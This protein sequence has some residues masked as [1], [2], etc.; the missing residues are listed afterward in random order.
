VNDL[1]SEYS[2]T[3]CLAIY[4]LVSYPG[5]DTIRLIRPMLQDATTG[6]R[7]FF[8][9]DPWNGGKEKRVKYYPVR[10]AANLALALLGEKLDWP[11]PF[12]RDDDELPDSFARGF[13]DRTYFP[14]GSWT[15]FEDLLEPPPKT[16]FDFL[17]G[18]TPV[19]QLHDWRRLNYTFAFQ[20]D[21][22]E[23]HKSVEAE[24]LPKGFKVA[25]VDPD[26]FGRKWRSVTYSRGG[27]RVSL[28]EHTRYMPQ[29]EDPRYTWAEDLQGW[30]S[31]D[32]I[33]GRSLKKKTGA[34]GG[35]N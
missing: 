2:Y 9:G 19:T 17:S 32:V 12:Y 23:T 35:R 24:L 15:R 14:N 10:E 5:K 11:V 28:I 6:E 26:T 13:E 22:A 18:R 20:A 7:T 34:T 27:D 30:V 25:K 3:R 16:P 4:N 31:C 21:F 29:K 1:K 33:L 8:D